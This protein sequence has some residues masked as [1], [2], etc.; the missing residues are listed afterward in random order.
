M[1]RTLRDCHTVPRD[2]LNVRFIPTIIEGA[3]FVE[4]DR[5]TDPRGGF[6]RT[7]CRDAFRE[8]GLTFAPVQCGLSTNPVRATLRGLHYQ[9]APHQEAK[10]VHCVSGSVFDVAVDLRR[11]SRSF[12]KAVATTLSEFGTHLFYIPRGC[13]HGFLTLERDSSVA[14]FI[15]SA[16]EAH[17][18]AGVRWNDPAFAIAWPAAPDL[19]SARD[20]AYPDF[21]LAVEGLP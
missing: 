17:A 6:Q 9:R 4:A 2:R 11:S 10:L 20:A 1:G 5:V 15:D 3:Y 19:I 8:A 16:F 21:D 14:Y 7:Y 12:G 13:A 18:G